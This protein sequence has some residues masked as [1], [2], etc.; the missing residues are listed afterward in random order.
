M[1]NPVFQGKLQE[2][3]RNYKKNLQEVTIGHKQE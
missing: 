1:E 2:T 3:T